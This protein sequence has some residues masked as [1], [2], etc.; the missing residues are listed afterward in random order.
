MAVETFFLFGFKALDDLITE[1]I[2]PSSTNPLLKI[3]EK[4]ESKQISDEDLLNLINKMVTKFIEVSF[5][6]E[7]LRFHLLKQLEPS[8]GHKIVLEIKNLKN[9]ILEFSK[10][11]NIV[12]VGLAT[13]KDF[14][15]YPVISITLDLLKKY[16]TEG[17]DILREITIGGIGIDKFHELN[18]IIVRALLGFSSS[19]FLKEE[20]RKK[21]K[22]QFSLLLNSI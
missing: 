20:F 19:Y 13:E 6:F 11:E 8:F 18:E 12:R 22:N 21:V 10:N 15:S 14:I 5:E 9:F 4:F 2:P 3:I 7:D 17:L 1:I 16:L